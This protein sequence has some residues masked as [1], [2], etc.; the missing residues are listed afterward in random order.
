MPVSSSPSLPESSSRHYTYSRK[1]KSLGL[2]CSNFL[3]LYNRE[4]V[5]LIGL[6]EA[7]AKLGV[8][9]HRIYD[10]VNVLESVGLAWLLE[11]QDHFLSNLM[12]RKKNKPEQIFFCNICEKMIKDL[13]GF[14]AHIKDR[15]KKSRSC[16]KC[17]MIFTS[18]VDLL[19]HSDAKE[20]YDYLKRIELLS[21]DEIKTED[22]ESSLEEVGE[23]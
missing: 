19:I 18:D 20:C 8:E 11:T 5:E 7:A 4:D 22:L 16:R 15:H 6:D 2:L 14:T 10:I 9:R 1:Q 21:Q 23:K 3:S 13:S 17:N 12:G